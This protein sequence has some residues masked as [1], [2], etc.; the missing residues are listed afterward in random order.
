MK[1]RLAKKIVSSLFNG[2]V[3]RKKSTVRRAL[4]KCHLVILENPD[5]IM[6]IHP[7]Y[8]SQDSNHFLDAVLYSFIAATGI[9]RNFFGT[10]H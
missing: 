10:D 6:E 7:T 4:R 2:K 9:P 8:P 3:H 1:K 5:A